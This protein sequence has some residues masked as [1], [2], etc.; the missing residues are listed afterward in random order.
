M[1]VRRLAG[2]GEADR[3]GAWKAT[4]IKPRA[5]VLVSPGCED[6]LTLILLR[7]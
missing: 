4:E 7:S 2:A 3:F 1:R 5:N 6:R